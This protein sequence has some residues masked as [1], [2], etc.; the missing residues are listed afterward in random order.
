MGL[1]KIPV[2]AVVGP[3][4]SGK[5]DLAVEICRRFGGEAVSA[6]SMQIYKGL[7][8]ST[9]K[10]TEE[11]KKGIPHHMMDFLDTR[12]SFSVAEYQSMA[13]ECIKEIHSRGKLP[14]I[15]GGTGLYI[16]NLL[17]NIRLTEAS[18]DEAL[19]E[20]LLKRV[21]D[22][23]I[24]ALLAE[25]EKIDPEYAAKMHPNNV[26]RIVRALEVWYSS[27]VTM[28]EQIANSHAESPYEVL[29]IGLD[30]QDRDFLYNR[31]N[32]RVDIMLANGLEAEARD[33]L[34][35]PDMSTSSQAIGCKELKPYFE[36]GMS[37]VQ[38][39]ENLKQATRRY[40][41]RQLTWFRRNKEINWLFIDTF[42]SKDA[43]YE[44]A[45]RITEEWERRLQ[46]VQR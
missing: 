8:I 38:A 33:Y 14:V 41:K 10:P 16:D 4:A 27:G 46:N 19:R 30:A 44:E 11:E 26:K 40:A 17:N 6:D 25:L 31:I 13:G 32:M 1:N 35:Q 3:T 21:E 29:Y 34:S 39:A 42:P 22:E 9:A 5:S 15:V 20:K 18:F 23:G 36:G 43:M 2:V 37:L 28:T 45:F 24:D 7:D 12:D